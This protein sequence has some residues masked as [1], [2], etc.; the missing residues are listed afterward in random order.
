MSPQEHVVKTSPAAAAAPAGATTTS[1]VV[2][3]AVDCR[4][5]VVVGRFG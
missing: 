4:M 1:S 5:R 2:T 3:A